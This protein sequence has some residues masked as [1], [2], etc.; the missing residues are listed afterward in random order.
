M[1]SYRRALI[2]GRRPLPS[3]HPTLFDSGHGRLSRTRRWHVPE[4]KQTIFAARG[5]GLC[6]QE[7]DPSLLV[8]QEN[9]LQDEEL[10]VAQGGRRCREAI[11]QCG[12]PGTPPLRPLPLAPTGKRWTAARIDH[13]GAAAWEAHARTQASGERSRAAA[14]SGDHEASERTALDAKNHMNQAAAVVLHHAQGAITRATEA[15]KVNK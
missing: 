1:A 13:R 9:G 4:G 8:E 3:V 7:A 2:R 15:R 5:P 12:G 10:I 11:W 6:P 14:Q